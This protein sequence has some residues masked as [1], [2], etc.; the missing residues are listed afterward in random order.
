M[1]SFNIDAENNITAF[2]ISKEAEAAGDTF[3]SEAEL[4]ELT[5]A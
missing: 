3:R 2:A 1:K 4:H 5:A